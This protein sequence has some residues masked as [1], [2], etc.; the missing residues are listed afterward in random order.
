MFQVAT[1]STL[2]SGGRAVAIDSMGEAASAVGPGRK[3]VT[4]IRADCICGSGD[5][6][7]EGSGILYALL[8]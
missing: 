3:F 8:R 7:R 2:Y 4:V 5:C 1:F 6:C